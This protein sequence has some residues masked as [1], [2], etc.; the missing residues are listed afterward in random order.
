M[1]KVLRLLLPRL[2]EISLLTVIEDT[3]VCHSNWPKLLY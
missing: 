1:S 2:A 3:Y